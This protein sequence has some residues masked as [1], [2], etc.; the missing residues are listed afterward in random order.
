MG[1]EILVTRT[2]ERHKATIAALMF[3]LAAFAILYINALGWPGIDFWHAWAIAAESQRGSA[4]NIYS[5]SASEGIYKA[6]VPSIRLEDSTSREQVAAI[7]S[8]GA[9]EATLGYRGLVIIHTPLHLTLFR[10][11]NTGNYEH[12]YRWFLAVSLVCFFASTFALGRLI[13]FSIPLSLVVA[14]AIGLTMEAE[15]LRF[16][17]VN[18][19]QLAF[20]VA[21]LILQRRPSMW[22][23]V[24]SGAVLALVTAFKPN[25]GL[26][27]PAVG[28][29]W[30]GDRL[31]RKL[32]NVGAGLALGALM[33]LAFTSLSAWRDWIVRLSE[34]MGSFQPLELGNF[35]LS[36]VLAEWWGIDVSVFPLM[37]GLFALT[38]VSLR[39]LLS[40]SPLLNHEPVLFNRTLSAVSAGATLLILSSR[41]VWIHYVILAIP[42]M[43]VLARNFMDQRSICSWL[44]AL[45]VLP[46]TSGCL[47]ALTFIA[48]TSVWAAAALNLSLVVL[49]AWA[50]IS[51]WRSSTVVG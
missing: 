8:A 43:F 45:T 51:L 16:G 50:V 17:N 48:A 46:L 49:F 37:L 34:F 30:M 33:T 36:A 27:V 47:T 22:T 18:N 24:A 12:D 15:E 39:P 5:R 9:D 35:A 1:E 42:A 11:I 41:L 21:F 23:D 31:W 7:K 14:A 4:N 40:K 10:V 26:I 19:F 38:I 6:I 29:T 25:V 3:S 13:G 2:S 44:S 32:I 28:L 20:V